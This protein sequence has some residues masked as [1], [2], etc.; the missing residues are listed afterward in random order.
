M[1]SCLE[2]ESQFGDVEEEIRTADRQQ[3]ELSERSSAGTT[4]NGAVM[5]TVHLGR[6]RD[7]R[8]PAPEVELPRLRAWDLAPVD[9][10]EDKRRRARTRNRSVMVTTAGG[11]GCR[12]RRSIQLV[13]LSPSGSPQLH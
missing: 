8:T 5:P 2:A 1:S 6:S 12:S 7:L 11:R 9:L 13:E 10:V 4:V 3:E